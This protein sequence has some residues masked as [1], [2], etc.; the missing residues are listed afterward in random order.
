[1]PYYFLLFGIRNSLWCLKI[2]FC[3]QS[4]FLRFYADFKIETHQNILYNGQYGGADL[5]PDQ[6]KPDGQKA[7]KQSVSFDLELL[8][9]VMKYCQREERTINW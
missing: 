4:L 3:S 6:Q 9:R 1:M 5:W 8:A 2:C 7:V